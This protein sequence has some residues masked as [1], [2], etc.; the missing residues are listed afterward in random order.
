MRKVGEIDFFTIRVAY[1]FNRIFQHRHHP[2]SQQIDL[3]DAHIRTVL[4]IPL[5]HDPAG[6]RGGLQRHNGVQLPLANH[7]SAGM[8]SQVPREVL[9]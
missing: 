6:H 7:H 3:Q 2:E 4:F 8:L 9:R 5:N 1:Q